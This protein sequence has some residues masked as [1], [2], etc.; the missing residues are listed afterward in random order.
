MLLISFQSFSKFQLHT[1]VLCY[2]DDPNQ[3][4]E[5]TYIDFF[6]VFGTNNKFCSG[7]V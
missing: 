6:S 5:P 4:F 1:E 2:V 7:L 3:Y